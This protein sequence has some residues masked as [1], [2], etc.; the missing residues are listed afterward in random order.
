MNCDVV[1]ETNSFF[2]MKSGVRSEKIVISMLKDRGYDVQCLQESFN[3]VF[4][5]PL[6][7]E[8]KIYGKVDGILYK[9]GK[10]FAILEVKNRQRKYHNRRAFRSDIDQLATYGML[11]GIDKG[12]I[13][14]YDQQ[15]SDPELRLS[16]HRDLVNYWIREV[17]PDLDKSLDFMKHLCTHPDSAEANNF[18]H[19]IKN[20]LNLNI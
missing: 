1:A 11:T 2:N 5:T 4:V 13:V 15:D 7:T 18:L 8:Y 9:D 12:V 3:C 20:R 14:E 16:K 19:S 6:Q 17:K 10:R